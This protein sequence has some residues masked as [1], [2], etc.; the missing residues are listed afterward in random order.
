MAVGGFGVPFAE[1]W[2][3]GSWKYRAVPVPGGEDGVGLA[4]VSCTSA[5]WC[6][7]VGGAADT[8]TS[9]TRFVAEAW[10]GSQWQPLSLS[11]LPSPA[12][13]LELSSV[14]CS[15]TT[16]CTAVGGGDLGGD[17]IERW[18]GT[19]W[20]PQL[21]DVSTG[22]V[23][24]YAVSCP[25]DSECVAVGDGPTNSPVAERWDG[26]KWKHQGV[27]ADSQFLAPDTFTSVSCSSATRCAASG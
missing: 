7:A 23:E 25:S 10:N 26:S 17:A 4:G 14:S 3:N 19:R 8:A 18:D 9:S 5:S 11:T 21:P 22:L 24:L 27:P 2:T 6:V 1:L 16:S 20:S 13:T 15:S 12:P